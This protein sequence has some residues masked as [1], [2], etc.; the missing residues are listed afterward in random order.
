MTSHLALDPNA[1]GT[2]VF[3][4]RPEWSTLSVAL[5][6]EVGVIAGREDLLVT[7]A[8]GAGG[9]APACFYPTRAL[10]EVDGVHLG[11]DPATVDPTDPHDRAR[12]AT[13]WGLLTHECAHAAHSLWD[14]PDGTPPGIA[15]AAMVLEESR[16]EAAHIRRRPDD[17][18]WL[19]ASAVNL[20]LDDTDA[21]DPPSAQHMT[22]A[23]A[24]RTAA[25]I[26]ARVDGG[27]LTAA[28]TAPVADAVEKITGAPLLDELR[29]LWREALATAD[30][31]A[32][33]MIDIARRWCLAV[34]TDPDDPTPAP[35]PG[36]SGDHDPSGAAAS[37]LATAIA[38]TV[39]AV[40]AAV[41][42]QTPPDPA[43]IAAAAQAAENA[44]REAAH[45]AARTVFLSPV[46][47]K[48]T[49]T[50][51][52][53][54]TR[55]PTTGE[56][57]A[58]RVFGRA[59]STAGARDRV[60]VKTTSPFPPGRLRMRG[61]LAADA[62][63]AAGADVT[64]EPFTRTT[65][66]VVPAPPLKL[67]VA[68]DVSGSMGHLREPVASTAWILA[69]G[70]RHATVDVTTAT[71]IFGYSVRPITHPGAHPAN[72]TEF[73]ANDGSHAIATA[74]DALDGALGLTRP[75]AARLCVVISDGHFD[76]DERRAGQQRIDRLR[77]SGCA[78][79]WL[80]THTTDEP[81][82]GVAVHQLTDPAT[83]ARAI[84]RAAT[85]A[86]RAAH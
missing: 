23:D 27:I 15:D 85:A 40:S 74:A 79:L 44:A 80:T 46:R 84:G 36:G 19:R 33:T 60:A 66:L 59:L 10:I 49:G 1:T 24:A 14:P 28:E 64:A 7:I 18:L 4:A 63:R 29:G 5:T 9:G 35:M 25:L 86:L 30:D 78:V 51:A 77:A 50:T 52:T 61:V 8:P 13:A 26:L 48:R 55:P 57:T 68:C 2:A 17:R 58:A 70:G 82:T 76:P 69:H 34:G 16:M 22:T 39:A 3:P 72:V 71:V 56:R 37:A 65:R 67:A 75:G 73:A 20:I 62:Q 45:K 47:S 43:A 12:Y 32:D 41:A 42:A 83:T 54:G 11:V 6:D 81:F 31:D 38:A 21:T 53:T